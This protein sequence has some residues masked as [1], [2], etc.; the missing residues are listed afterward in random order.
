M[1]ATS[2]LKL[3]PVPVPD[4]YAVPVSF[5]QALRRQWKIVREQSFYEKTLKNGDVV[6]R[7]GTLLLSHKKFPF[8]LR[9]K[10]TA[11]CVGYAFEPPEAIE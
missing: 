10:F 4:Y 1:S 8:R 3:G 7:E 9:V 6:K 2:V 11:D 5:Q